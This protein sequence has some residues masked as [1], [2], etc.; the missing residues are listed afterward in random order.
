M[1]I[2]VHLISGVMVGMEFQ[3]EENVLILDLGIVRLI[4]GKD[5]SDD[6]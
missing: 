5:T 1:F 3:W 4:I 2:V 6:E